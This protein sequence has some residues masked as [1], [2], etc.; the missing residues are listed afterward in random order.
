[1][2]AAAR[3][4][5]SFESC[6]RCRTNTEPL[7]TWI[8]LALVLIALVMALVRPNLGTN[9]LGKA[10]Q[11]F[12]RLAQRQALAVLVVGLLALC[13]RA[14]VLPL[15][16]VPQPSINDEFRSLDAAGR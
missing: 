13:A 1:M 12:S 5:F 2:G 15:L 7:L 10:E 16:P 6:G 9:W 3:F 11:C 8:E 14:A 4:N